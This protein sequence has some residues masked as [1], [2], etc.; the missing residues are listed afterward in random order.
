MTSEK[1]IYEV[2]WPRGTKKI[3]AVTYAKRP[4]S[5]AGKTVGE[6]WDYLFQG[7]SIFPL[8]EKELAK[9]YPGIKFVSYD[10]F[11]RTLG[12]D[13]DEVLASLSDKL[14]QYNCDVVISAMGC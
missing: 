11:G 1:E 10:V 5:L 3:Q 12:G 2:I 4:D 8:I 6:L 7:D 9:R 13:D 14:K